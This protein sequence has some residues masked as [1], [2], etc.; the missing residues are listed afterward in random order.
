[1]T[2]YPNIPGYHQ[3]APETSPEAA[4]AITSKAQRLRTRLYHLLA[5][6]WTGTADEAASKLGESILSVRPR[7]SELRAG[8]AIIDTGER[9]RNESGRNAVVW[10]LAI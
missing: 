9:R 7:F 4:D 6:G 5:T 3:S 2:N 8:D 10:R 1:M